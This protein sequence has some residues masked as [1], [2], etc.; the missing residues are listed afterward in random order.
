MSVLESVSSKK[1]MLVALTLLAVYPLAVIAARLEFWHFSNSFLLFIVTALVSFAVL[2][3]GMLKL[4]KSAKSDSPAL[5]VAIIAALLPLSILGS[6]VYKTQKYPLIHDISTDV[7]HAPQ[8]KAAALVRLESDHSVEYLADEVAPLQLKGYNVGPLRVSQNPIEVFTV[9]KTLME[10]RGWKLLASENGQMPFTLEA[11]HT[12][13]LFGFTDDVV[14]R[15]QATK[16][17]SHVDMRSMSRVGKSDM[18][19]NAKRIQTFLSELSA[20]LK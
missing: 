2:A 4:S 7:E 9:A 1:V 13:L 5:I 20:K 10:A 11:S 19:V 18:G 16:E 17:G 8:L 3:I 12:T 6:Y 15:I 14:L